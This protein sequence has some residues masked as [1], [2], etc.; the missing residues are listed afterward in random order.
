M[1]SLKDTQFSSILSKD[2]SYLFYL[3][4]EIGKRNID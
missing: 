2:M 1:S 4:E 3:Q